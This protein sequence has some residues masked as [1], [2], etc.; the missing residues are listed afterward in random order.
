MIILNLAAYFRDKAE[1]KRL[2]AEQARL[3]LIHDVNFNVVTAVNEIYTRHRF[4]PLPMPQRQV[5]KGK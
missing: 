1:A 4:R 5:V 2:A 3:D